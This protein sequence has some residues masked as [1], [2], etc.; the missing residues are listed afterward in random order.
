[1]RPLDERSTSIGLRDDI[2]PKKSVGMG[3]AKSFSRISVSS[4]AT[5]EL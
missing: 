4:G 1:M 5:T 2:E 3:P